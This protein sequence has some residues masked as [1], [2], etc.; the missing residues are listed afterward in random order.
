V[1][2]P[3]HVRIEYRERHSRLTTLARIFMVVPHL[4]VVLLLGLAAWALTVVAWFAIL[5]IGRYPRALFGFVAGTL[6]YS[7]RVGCY[8]LLVTD[9]FPPFGPG[10]GPDGYPVT[11]W[12]DEPG[13]R[14]RL[15]TGLRLLL[16]VPAWLV[17]YF[18]MILAATMS[19]VAWWIVVATGRLPYGMFEVMALCHRYQ[20]R[21]AAYTWL[22][23][24]DYPWFQAESGSELGPWGTEIA[25]QTAPE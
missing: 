14:S 4:V 3:V 1:A 19:F 11:V 13:R 25:M 6:R 21:V 15:T 9:R 17:L 12:V 8:W 24:D 2:Y 10:A 16:A 7:M 20:A 22:L 23:T 5:A 18:L